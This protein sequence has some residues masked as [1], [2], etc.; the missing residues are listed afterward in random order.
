M[1]RLE[2]LPFL[3]VYEIFRLSMS[4]SKLNAI[5]QDS[6]SHHFNIIA[7]NFWGLPEVK[8]PLKSVK[9]LAEIFMKI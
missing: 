4:S 2:L 9:D 6:K 3:D 1:M 7:Q 5:I 8:K